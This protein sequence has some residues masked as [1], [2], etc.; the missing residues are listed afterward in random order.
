MEDNGRNRI[1]IQSSVWSILA[2]TLVIATGYLLYTMVPYFSH[3][4]SGK[5]IDFLPVLATCLF[6]G[7]FTSCLFERLYNRKIYISTSYK[8]LVFIYRKLK[9]LLAGEASS[10]VFSVSDNGYKHAF[11][12]ILVKIFY[13][14]LMLQF[15]VSNFLFLSDSAL[16]GN[17]DLSGDFLSIFNFTVY[18]FLIGACFFVDT[19]FFLFGYLIYSDALGNTIKSVETTFLGWAVALLCYPP[20]NYIT[21]NFIPALYHDNPETGDTSLTFILRFVMFVFLLI[22]TMAT[23]NLGWKCSNLTNRGIVSHGVYAIVRHPAYM[24]KNLFWWL[25]L[26]PI[27]RNKPEA[28]FY[29]AGWSFL[30]F[31]RAVT[32]ERHLRHDPDYVVYCKKVKYRFIPKIY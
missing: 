25:S 28:V 6:I 2:D 13:V 17:N 9:M 4:L 11:F 1:N 21:A 15:M 29:M 5:I 12:I 18:P 19:L 16:S 23:V 20:F 26:L 14:P 10:L 3:V 24:A 30:Y 8:A 32:E 31:L 27:I 22:Y 7:S